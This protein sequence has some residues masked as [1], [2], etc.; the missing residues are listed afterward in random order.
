MKSIAVVRKQR[1]KQLGMATLYTLLESIQVI[2]VCRMNRYSL[3]FH[4]AKIRSNSLLMVPIA[5]RVAST[6]SITD[7]VTPLNINSPSTETTH[8]PS[9]AAKVDQTIAC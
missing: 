5:R 6:G 4:L 9:L 7:S 2:L 1:E 8:M 3:Q